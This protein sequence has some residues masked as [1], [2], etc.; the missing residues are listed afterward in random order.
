MANGRPRT[1]PKIERKSS[2]SASEIIQVDKVMNKIFMNIIG[3]HVTIVCRDI[4]N[5]EVYD[6]VK[7]IL[8]SQ[9]FVGG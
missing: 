8:I 2:S 7:E 6:R 4:S 1:L 5:Y 9:F 3:C